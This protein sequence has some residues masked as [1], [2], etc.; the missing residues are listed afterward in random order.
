MSK[1]KRR[2]ILLAAR[3]AAARKDHATATALFAAVGISYVYE[4]NET[5]PFA[6]SN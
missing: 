1:A 6:V 5:V 4:K 3:E 2:A